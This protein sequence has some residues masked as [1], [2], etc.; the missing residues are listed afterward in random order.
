LSRKLSVVS[1]TTA[2][3]Q[4]IQLASN[5]LIKSCDQMQLS[6]LLIIGSLG[7]N[8]AYAVDPILWRRSIT[9]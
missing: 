2:A 7:K 4:T 8:Y 3:S 6:L 5:G 1:V 9:A